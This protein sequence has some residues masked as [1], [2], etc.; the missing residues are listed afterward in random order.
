MSSNCDVIEANVIA[1]VDDIATDDL[2]LIFNGKFFTLVQN[3]SYKG[4]S[5]DTKQEQHDKSE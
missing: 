5:K 4:D 2:P 3:K 1:V